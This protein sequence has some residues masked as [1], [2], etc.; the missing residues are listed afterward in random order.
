MKVIIK[1]AAVAGWVLAIVYVV[2]LVLG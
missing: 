2:G 1:V